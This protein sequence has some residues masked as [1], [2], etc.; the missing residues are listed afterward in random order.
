MFYLRISVIILFILIMPDA[1]ASAVRYAKP[2]VLIQ[3]SSAV[4]IAE[5]TNVTS[6]S[7]KCSRV[8]HAKLK[9]LKVLKGRLAAG[10]ELELMDVILIFSDDCPGKIYMR[11][12]HVTNLQ[13]GQEIIA[14][15]RKQVTDRTVYKV[16]AS[17]EMKA[18]EK[19][20]KWF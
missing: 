18:L 12:P 4:V 11:A 16:T 20:K 8:I 9:T 10:R 1:I 5:V 2:E 3:N 19:I 17:F 7:K 14:V 6:D 15:V 13:V